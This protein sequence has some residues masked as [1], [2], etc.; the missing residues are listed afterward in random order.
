MKKKASLSTLGIHG[1]N[2]QKGRGSVS[3]P[4][5]QTSTYRLANS[6]DAKK[7]A[8]GDDSVLV[9]SR[10][11]NP[12]VNEVERRL[13]ALEGAESAALF[14]SG[15]AAISTAVLAFCSSGDEIVSTPS[16]YGGTYRFFRDTLPRFN[17]ATKYVD[18]QSLEELVYLVTPKTKLVWLETP[19]NPTLEIVDIAKL[20]KITRVLQR[21]FGNRIII[22]IDN[23]FAT[24][25][26]QDPFQLGVDLVVE[27]S[28]KYLN[29]HTDILGGAVTGSKKDIAAIKGLAKH[30]GGTTDPFAA[31]LL[32]RSLKTFELRVRKHN[33]NAFAFAKAMEKNK[34]VIRVLYPGLRS[35]PQHAL[36]NKQMSG[37]G[38]MVTIEVRGGAKGAVRVVD[39]LRLALNAMSLGGVET[40]V[41]IPVYSSHIG[42]T[43]D[44]LAKH[45]VTPGMIRVSVGLEGIDDLIQDF[46]RALKR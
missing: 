19:T 45:G 32:G 13:A 14:S 25:L 33:E 11:H 43:A 21:E 28:T 30:F 27:S 17:I 7:Y 12:T 26:N 10:Y 46:S 22:A 31:F 44:E 4:I 20:V 36:A 37:F 2:D 41:S 1:L 15:M 5:H 8:K 42:M 35:H 29:G 34:N 38:G 40:L 6:A 3:F 18:P 9:Y 39:K 16:L 24:I 23:T